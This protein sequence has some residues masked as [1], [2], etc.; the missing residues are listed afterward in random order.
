MWISVDTE[1]AWKMRCLSFFYLK[2]SLGWERVQTAACYR[3]QG[4]LLPKTA[5]AGVDDVVFGLCLHRLLR[6][7][8]QGTALA[9]Y[10]LHT[11]QVPAAD[12]FGTCWLAMFHWSFNVS[13]P[14]H[15]KAKE[16]ST[17]LLIAGSF[18]TERI[19]T[20]QLHHDSNL[21]SNWLPLS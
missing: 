1:Y 11:Y 19:S 15:A 18:L 20:Y 13:D 4:L 12:A 17:M 8:L 2:G 16:A 6:G 3:S 9:L 5:S 10:A 21:H 14:A 7:P